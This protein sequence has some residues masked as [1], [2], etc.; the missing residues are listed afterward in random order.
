MLLDEW[1]TWRQIKLKITSWNLGIQGKEVY[2]MVSA[3]RQNY[4]VVWKNYV[5]PA[6]CSHVQVK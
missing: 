6:L 3:L 1:G 4:N 5:L 2:D